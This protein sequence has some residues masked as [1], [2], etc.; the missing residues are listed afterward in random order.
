MYGWIA[1]ME[2]LTAS[3]R[4]QT[5]ANADMK[6]FLNLIHTE[7]CKQNFN[8]HSI[9]EQKCQLIDFSFTNSYIKSPCAYWIFI[10]WYLSGLKKTPYIS[11]NNTMNR[12]CRNS[13]CLCNWCSHLWL[14][15]MFFLLKFALQF[16]AATLAF[17]LTLE[18]CYPICTDNSISVLVFCFALLAL[19]LT[20]ILYCIL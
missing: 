7:H 18:K 17:I 8:T 4:D 1:D 10:Q 16:C 5:V 15:I 11:G 6:S 12:F 20:Y 19:M 9:R 2:C 13:W 3:P 14:H